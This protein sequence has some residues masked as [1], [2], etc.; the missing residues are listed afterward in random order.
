[1]RGSRLR[2][3]DGNRSPSTGRVQNGVSAG[4]LEE[5]LEKKELTP[6]EVMVIRQNM[7]QVTRLYL[8]YSAMKGLYEPTRFVSRCVY[9][10]RLSNQRLTTDRVFHES[11]RRFVLH[12]VSS[13]LFQ[14]EVRM[15]VCSALENPRK[16]LFKEKSE[17]I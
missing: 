7:L 12:A 17:R 15:Y 13:S 5:I 11:P 16:Q 3:R 1:M 2:P 14:L 8:W 4:E 6:E 10:P 9:F